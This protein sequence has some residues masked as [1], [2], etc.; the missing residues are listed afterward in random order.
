ME[1]R[2]V[3]RSTWDP[4]QFYWNVWVQAKTK[5]AKI[6]RKIIGTRSWKELIANIFFENIM[7]FLHNISSKFENGCGALK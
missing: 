1:R 2:Q 6:G 4:R 7:E 3:S 5:H